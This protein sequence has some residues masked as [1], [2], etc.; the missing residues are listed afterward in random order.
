[1]ATIDGED[2]LEQSTMWATRFMNNPDKDFFVVD[3]N[4]GILTTG[5]IIARYGKIGN[6][7]ISEVGLYQKYTGDDL[8]SSRYMYL[9]YPGANGEDESDK[10]A[11]FAGYNKNNPLFTVN[12]KGYMSARAGKIG[13]TSPWYISDEGLVQSL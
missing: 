13:E 2:S 1:L 11:I 9:G 8:A 5:G 4:N 7:L 12:W 10:Y 6:W 3:P